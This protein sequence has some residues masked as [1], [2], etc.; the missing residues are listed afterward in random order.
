[1][2]MKPAAQPDRRS[3]RPDAFTL[4]LGGGGVS[5]IAWMTGLLAGLE[6]AGIDLRPAARIIGTS[7]GATV[8][9]QLSSGLSLEQLFTRQ[10]DPAHRAPEIAPSFSQLKALLDAFQL[11]TDIS[12][13]LEMRKQMGKFAINSK[14]VGEAERRNIIAGRLP[15][16]EWPDLRLQLTA[17]DAESGELRIFDRDTGVCVIDAVAASCAVPG[18]W[19]PVTI[20]NR[21][22]IDGG[23]RSAD[24]ADLAAGDAIVI[25]LSPIGG[26]EQGRGPS[27][28]ANEVGSLQATGSRVLAIQ[29]SVAARSAMGLNAL[30]PATQPAAATAGRAQGSQDAA[31]IRDWTMG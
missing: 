23:F 4:V 2:N 29:P 15:S 31:R 19:P 26:L 7:A 16:H 10:T 13:P 5:G 21:R 1:M 17:I 9:A 18:V 22:F 12:D 25:V 14:T 11:R 24:N 3:M 6:D 28:L 27:T 8:D 30:D 20:G